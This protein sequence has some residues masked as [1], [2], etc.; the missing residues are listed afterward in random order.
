MIYL[1]TILLAEF[2]LCLFLCII[3]FYDFGTF[4]LIFVLDLY[5]FNF[6]TCY[7]IRPIL[8]YIVNRFF[9]CIFSLQNYLPIN[10]DSSWQLVLCKVSLSVAFV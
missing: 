9:V 1:V 7:C 10:L 3:M 8:D 4:S 5:H 2:I 6:A